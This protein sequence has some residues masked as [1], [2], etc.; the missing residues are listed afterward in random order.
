MDR[1][2]SGDFP[3][4]TRSGTQFGNTADTAN[5]VPP[6]TGK[7]RGRPRQQGKSEPGTAVAATT[8]GSGVR[9]ASAGTVVVEGSPATDRDGG[10]SE[11]EPLA[12]EAT[13][14][15]PSPALGSGEFGALALG[16][17]N[18]LAKGLEA[19]SVNLGDQLAKVQ[20][21]LSEELASR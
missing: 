11:P 21:H 3:L 19:I 9:S 14:P 16:L 18:S 7:G 15:A 8:V 6:P 13:T 4:R 5:G 2:E 20:D 1:G 12:G 17:E 10:K